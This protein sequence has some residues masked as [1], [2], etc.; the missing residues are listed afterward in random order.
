MNAKIKEKALVVLEKLNDKKTAAVTAA[1]TSAPAL[2]SAGVSAAETG[3]GT[4]SVTIPAIADSVTA[5]MLN[6][7]ITQMTALLP[8]CLPTVVGLLAFRKGIGFLFG[9]LRGA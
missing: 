7:I 8:I 9:L 1:V 4:S 2:L 5:D 6:G 3:G